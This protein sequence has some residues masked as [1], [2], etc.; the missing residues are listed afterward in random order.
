MDGQQ[1]LFT[2][3]GEHEQ[4]DLAALDKVNHLVLIAAAVNVT[5]P[6]NLDGTR[7]DRLAVQR[8]A[9]LLFELVGLRGLLNRH[10]VSFRSPRC[11]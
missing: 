6:G 1:T 11:L 4:F 3:G 7:I 2:F 10:H 5:V 9:Q 8:I